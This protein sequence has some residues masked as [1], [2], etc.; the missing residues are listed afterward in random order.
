MAA[1][2][3][4]HLSLTSQ[5]SRTDVYQPSLWCRSCRLWHLAPPSSANLEHRLCPF[6]AKTNFGL[7]SNR[8]P[9]SCL[10]RPELCFPSRRSTSCCSPSGHSRS[11]LS[12]HPPRARTPNSS[13]CSIFRQSLPTTF[14]LPRTPSPFL[15]PSPS[16]AASPLPCPS[17]YRSPPSPAPS[18]FLLASPSPSASPP[19]FP[20]P[21]PPHSAGRPSSQRIGW[22]DRVVAQ[23]L[24]PAQARI[25]SC[26]RL[27]PSSSEPRY[28]PALEPFPPPWPLLL[29]VARLRRRRPLSS[30]LL[31]A[32]SL[33]FAGAPALFSPAPSS[34]LPP[35]STSSA[36]WFASWS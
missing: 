2:C 15:S 30:P 35:P 18:A 27:F 34:P 26:H 32:A 28:A 23:K 11:E 10:H 20:P 7:A 3:S 33:L 19:P 8:S 25:R 6:F 1:R 9:T 21:S 4:K 14:H 17:P 13:S 16:R 22:P 29:E 31:V 36:P 12:L 24:K 5:I